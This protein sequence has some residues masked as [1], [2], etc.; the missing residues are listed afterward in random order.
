MSLRKTKKQA[1]PESKIYI[2]SKVFDVFLILFMLILSVI[3]LYPFLNVVAT[4][5]S[6]NRMITTGQ[7][8]FFPRELMV[9]GYKMLWTEYPEPTEHH[10]DSGEDD[11]HQPFLTSLMAYVMMVPDFVLRKQC[12]YFC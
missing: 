6:S 11:G 10:C 9:D 7:V 12:P 2:G 1:Q 5:L 3:F 4:S 8:T